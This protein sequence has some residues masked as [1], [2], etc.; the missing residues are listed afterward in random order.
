LYPSTYSGVRGSPPGAQTRTPEYV[1]GY[2]EGYQ[3]RI[4]KR[5]ENAFIGGLVGGLAIL[6]LGV[7][8]LAIDSERRE[9]LE[10]E[11]SEHATAG[12]RS[13]GAPLLR[14]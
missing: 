1:D 8:I 11:T 7:L 13:R 4:E 3:A 14:F 5:R 10:G 12:G 6:A 9:N 2:N